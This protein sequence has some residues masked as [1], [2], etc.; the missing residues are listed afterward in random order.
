MPQRCEKRVESPTQVD[1]RES[2]VESSPTLPVRD[3]ILEH[4]RLGA[5]GR[6]ARF[7]HDPPR[8]RLLTLDCRLSTLDSRLALHC[9]LL[10]QACWLTLA[11]FGFV[12]LVFCL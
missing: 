7:E 3:E 6:P 11:T 12:A 4:T 1:S 9:R 8:C 2:R 10:L 5:G